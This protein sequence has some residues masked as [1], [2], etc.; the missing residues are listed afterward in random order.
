MEL[1]LLIVLLIAAAVAATFYLTGIKSVPIVE[2]WFVRLANGEPIPEKPD[3]GWRFWLRKPHE[4]ALGAARKMEE[5]RERIR[6]LEEQKTD[7]AH[8]QD[9]I[10]GSLLEGVLIVNS[11]LEIVLVNSE[12]LNIYQLQQSPLKRPINDALGDANLHQMVQNTFRTGQVQAERINPTPPVSR[13]STPS[14]EVSAIPFADEDNGAS[15][16][17]VVF[18]PPPDRTRMVRVLKQHNEKVQRLADEWVRRGKVLVRSTVA[19]LPDEPA[20][21]SAE[22]PKPQD[23]TEQSDSAS[24]KS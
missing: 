9:C 7:F 4:E 20:K 2:D 5:L 17:I 1:F 22:P 12:L 14:F 18:L 16:V 24:L 19:D 6:V 10:L 11:R 21:T 8:M 3:F 15:F 23:A 13:G